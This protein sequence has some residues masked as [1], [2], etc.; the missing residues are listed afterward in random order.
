MTLNMLVF[1]YREVEKKFFRE[2]KF[3]NLNI[4]FYKEAL[5]PEFLETI[6]QEIL[7]DTCII[8]V[9]INS[10][11]N[12]KV[13]KEFK[14]LRIIAT[15]STGYD[16]IDLR[17]CSN[18]NVA[19]VNVENYGATSVAQY[20]FGLIL[21]LVRKVIPAITV[22]K[23][24]IHKSDMIFNGKDLSKMTIGVVGTGA[25][26]AAVCR[27]AKCFGMKILA[28]DVCQK[29]ELV[30]ELKLE[31]MSLEELLEKSDIVTAHVPYTGHNYHMF[32]GKQF[33]MM[34]KDAYFLNTSRGE[35]VDLPALYEY[36]ENGHIAGVALDVLTCES[37]GFSC[38]Q[39]A[40]K[41]NKESLECYNEAKAVEK[42][43]KYDNVIITPH[44]AY[45]TQDAVDYI[46]ESTMRSINHII[47]GGDTNRI[48]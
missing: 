1:E 8:S 3:D 5:T 31:Y 21:L 27:L 42:L 46:L 6:S 22:V 10:V 36:V 43:C 28:Y 23:E 18:K 20:T 47:C 44:I 45:S 4:K 16:H 29:K 37:I 15:R 40:S 30:E 7:N 2:H 26:G 24:N 39:L 25:I 32:S 14:N 12:E 38:K 35:I 9:F 33:S 11:V 48:V 17:A 34:K 19:V 41:L 13:V